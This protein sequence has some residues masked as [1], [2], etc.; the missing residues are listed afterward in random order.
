MTLADLLQIA[1]ADLGKQ[2]V[3]IEFSREI[4]RALECPNCH[5][6]EEAFA[7]VGMVG[8]EQGK[9]PR[10]GQMRAV[11]PIHSFSGVEAFGS[12]KLNRLGL[13][14]FDIFTARSSSGEI[15]YLLADDREQILGPG[16]SGDLE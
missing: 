7:P 5:T 13:P 9:C 14:L 4:I 12:R 11:V 16:T 3:V 6:F 15:S 10:D 1:R 8:A 2:D